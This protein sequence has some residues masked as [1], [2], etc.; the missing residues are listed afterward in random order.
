MPLSFG[1]P[2]GLVI[3]GVGIAV[4]I[5]TRRKRLSLVIVSL[6]IVIFLLTLA[7]VFLAATSS[8]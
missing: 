7:S 2:I 8:M 3:A 4:Y 1:I 6:G 5:V